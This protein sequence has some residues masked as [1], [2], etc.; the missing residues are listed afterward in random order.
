MTNVDENG[1]YWNPKWR[2]RKKHVGSEDTFVEDVKEMVSTK[3]KGLLC[4][5]CHKRIIWRKLSITYKVELEELH[6]FWWCECGSLIKE[7]QIT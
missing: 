5:Q 2:K 3:D 1:R 6:R 4:K 7:E